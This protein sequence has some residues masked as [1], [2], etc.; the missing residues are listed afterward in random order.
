MWLAAL[1]AGGLLLS[2]KGK[3]KTVVKKRD[4]FGPRSGETWAVE[5]FPDTGIIVVHSTKGEPSLGVFHKK[6]GKFLFSK[7][8]GNVDTIGKMR[9]DFEGT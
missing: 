9:E 2:M 1:L 6:E 3:P 5:D 4:A 8:K 7:G